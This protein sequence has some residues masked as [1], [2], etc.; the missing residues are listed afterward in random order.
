[1]AS[2]KFVRLLSQSYSASTSP[3]YA[4]RVSVSWLLPAWVL[5]AIRALISLYA[6]VV[7]FT[8]IGIQTTSGDSEA[9]SQSFSFF[10]VLGYWGLAF[11][12][13]FASAHTASQASRGRAWL[14]TWPAILRFLHSTFYMTITVFPFIVTG[15]PEV[16][17]MDV[18][19]QSDFQQRYI[20][21]SCRR[22]LSTT[23]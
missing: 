19:L 1:M 17:L 4:H 5:F 7:L 6:F 10:T 3:E 8:R 14:E 15:K 12:F 18:S 21:P 16:I 23:N 11:Y 9:A 22:A 20:G 2:N 13:A